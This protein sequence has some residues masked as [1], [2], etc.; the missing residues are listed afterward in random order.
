MGGLTI[1]K[2]K[3]QTAEHR[4][5][6]TEAL[7]TEKKNYVNVEFARADHGFFCD[8]RAAYEPNSARQAWALTLE[9]L[10]S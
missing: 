5:A 6:I 9:F 7:T 3:A 10:R 8:E 4:R 1:V 2:E